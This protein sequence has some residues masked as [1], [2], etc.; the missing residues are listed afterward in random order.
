MKKQ[1]LTA[2][3]CLYFFT[4][5]SQF[6]NTWS[7]KLANAI[8]TRHTPTINAMT[9]KGWEYS[10]SIVLH[11]MEKVYYHTLD[12]S[13]LAYIKAYVDT[14]VDASGNI[15]GLAQNLDKIHPGII[16]LFLWEKTGLLKYKTAATNLR[17]YLMNGAPA[18]PTTPNGGY[19]HKN[20]GSYNDIMMADGIYMAHPFLAK[21]GALF[22]DNAA[23]DKA[24]SQT[25]LLAGYLQSANNLFKHAWNYPKTATWCDPATGV[26]KEVWSRGMGWYMMALV[27]ILKYL[28]A[29][30]ANYTPMKNLLAT[31]AI[32]IQNTQ[33][34]TTGL[35]YQVVD[36]AGSAGNYLETSGSAMF[37]YALKTAVTYGWIN[38]SFLTVAQNG[39]TGL[40]T[41][42]TTVADGPKVN[43]FAPAM[44]V[45]TNYS[46]Y[47][48]IT[49]VDCP[50]SVHP[51]GYAAI[52]MAGSVMEF[53]A[54]SMPVKFASFTATRKNHSVWLK[55]A[56]SDNE[57]AAQ[58][59]I[60]RSENGIHFNGFG[61]LPPNKSGKYDWVDHL[62][63]PNTNY[64][65]IKALGLDGTVCYSTVINIYWSKS[66]LNIS[67]L[68]N[69]VKNGYLNVQV[70]DLKS[71]NYSLNVVNSGGELI[72]SK[73]FKAKDGRLVKSLRLPQGLHKGMYCV[74]LKGGETVA[75]SKMVLVD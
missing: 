48:A 41:K 23:L 62:P 51:H 75:V 39:W 12:A 11:G 37:V 25:M 70:E 66:S 1:L 56:N 64:Y 17:N 63:A 9:G 24:A 20:N 13:Y 28:P 32:G 21:Y 36:K 18:Y 43:D 49:S 46:A 54:A 52:L 61:N 29:S 40:Q 59:I 7:V 38:A 73:T 30:H 55:W 65:R 4:S 57:E 35:W 53:S 19:W 5:Y 68:P 47:V 2:L 67:V 45:Q 10:N 72:V 60:E 26:S 15:T 44:G 22:G 33:D 31:L 6:S 34:P 3:L 58:F 71:G 16:C 27:D 42:I 74:Q 50:G 8:L 69:P 14:Y